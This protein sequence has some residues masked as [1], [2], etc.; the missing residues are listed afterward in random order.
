MSAH[1][2]RPHKPSL[3]FTGKLTWQ[4]LSDQLGCIFCSKHVYRL[5]RTVPCL[6]VKYNA[7]KSNCSLHE[8]MT[9]G[10]AVAND[11]LVNLNLM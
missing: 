3:L 7:T 9:Q 11:L 10:Y 1:F 2:A 5:L 6:M 4:W 8:T